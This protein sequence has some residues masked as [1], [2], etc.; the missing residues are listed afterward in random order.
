MPLL[1]SL[2]LLTFTDIIITTQ[3]TA[4]FVYTFADVL[5]IA[6]LPSAPTYVQ[7]HWLR[8]LLCYGIIE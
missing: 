6:T 7:Q 3:K 1:C 4:E 8:P 5:V 2:T